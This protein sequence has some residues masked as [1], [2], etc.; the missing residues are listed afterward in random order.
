VELERD[1]I[2]IALP[3]KG[4]LAEA[5]LSFLEGAG[6]RVHKPN[7]RQFEATI[8]SIP[9]LTVLFQRA[10]D[11][12]VSVRDGSV[13]FGITGMDAVCE[14]RGSNGA[15]LNLLE[16]LGFGHCSLWVIV[17]ESWK[18]VNQMADVRRMCMKMERPLRVAT[19]FPHLT[20]AFFQEQ[21]IDE[22]ALIHAEG[23]LEAAPAIGYADLIVDLVSTGTTLHDNRLRTLDDGLILE[24][25]TCLIA[26]RARLKEYPAALAM[27]R[28]LIEFIDAHM[29]AAKNVAIFA[30]MRG[31]SPEAIAER[32]FSQK[33][34]GGL[35]G[36]TISPVITRERENW[37]A[38]HIIVL[39]ERL[40][41][42]ITELRAIGGSGVVVAPVTYIFEEEP[43]SYKAMLKALE[44]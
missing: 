4:R 17:P 16:E 23:T 44:A 13:D 33:V 32:I 38:I 40:A 7:P 25:Q 22:L 10:G 43:L 34:I 37:F 5:T 21:G 29:N 1:D 19:K 36:P 12:V 35:Q 6:L 24:S 27:A 31:E 42:A 28:Q 2:R 26:N 20:A 3:S 14:K 15:I 18:D 39:R 8:P 30:N 11:I 9:H 41:E